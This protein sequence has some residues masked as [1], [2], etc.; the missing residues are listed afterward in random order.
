MAPPKP[1]REERL[2]AAVPMSGNALFTEELLR[3]QVVAFYASARK[4]ATLGPI[5]ERAVAEESWPGHIETITQFWA[6]I[7]V[8]PYK[9]DGTPRYSGRPVPAHMPLG[10]EPRHFDIW[11]QIWRETAQEI[12]PQADYPGC[13]ALLDDRAQLIARSL[14]LA[15]FYKPEEKS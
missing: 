11:L 13:A 15:L 7:F 3:A 9:P 2:V 14:K 4:D 10:L 5:F 6:Q 8:G 1:N 12:F